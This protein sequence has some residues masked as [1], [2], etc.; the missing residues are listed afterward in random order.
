MEQA[1]IKKW[2]K[3]GGIA[4]LALVMMRIG[5]SRLNAFVGVFM[6][7][8]AL[9]EQYQKMQKDGMAAPG[10]EMTRREAMNVLG[11]SEG[12]SEQDIRKAHRKLMQSNHPD[13]GGSEYLASKINQARDIL[14]G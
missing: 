9:V 14:L 6:L 12:A 10:S 1:D 8:A 11:V 13:R 4:G 5:V 3:Y 2:L 7:L